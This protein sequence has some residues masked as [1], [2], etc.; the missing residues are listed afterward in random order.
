MNMVEI[1]DRNSL[2]TLPLPRQRA[3]LN[4]VRTFTEQEFDCLAHG[5]IP[6]SMDDKWFIFMENDVLSF[7][8]SWTGVCIYQVH[9]DKRHAITAVWVNRDVQQYKETDNEYDQRLLNFLIDNLLLGQSTPFPMPSNLPGSLPKG[10]FQ[11]TV[12]RTGYPK[13]RDQ[14]KETLRTKV[15]RIFGR[16]SN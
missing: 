3:K 12:S 13:K 4:F 10:A 11:H 8:R 16:K 6:K 7:H 9:F 15:L 1:A 5:L 14:E 2:K